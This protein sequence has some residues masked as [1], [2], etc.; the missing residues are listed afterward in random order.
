LFKFIDSKVHR[1]LLDDLDRDGDHPGRLAIEQAYGYMV[2]NAVAYGII[3]TV[4]AFI[5]LCREIGGIL[6]ITRL[7]DAT[8]NNPTILQML[9]YMSHLCATTD[10]LYETH[11]DGR[12]ICVPSSSSGYSTAAIVPPPSIAV[13]HAPRTSVSSTNSRRS[14]RFQQAAFSSE[15]NKL[16]ASN[17]GDLYLD[18]DIHLPGTHLG[19]KGYRGFLHTGEKVFAKLWDGW[20]H[21]SKEL[22]LEVQI[23]K[24]LQPLGTTVPRM[25][26][27]G[28]WGFCHVL[29]L[30]FIE[31][32]SVI[33]ISL[34]M[35]R[36]KNCQKSMSMIQSRKT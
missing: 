27:Y 36:A 31:V 4:N 12:R 13:S 1:L 23:Y 34:L 8:T 10:L 17:G 25:I 19:C 3:T 2:H 9:Y 22:D 29:L 5:F 20:K 7:I 15:V 16:S 18:I 14:P 11:L 33:F 35:R 21:S 6:K 24:H 28:G 26:A 30:E 32:S